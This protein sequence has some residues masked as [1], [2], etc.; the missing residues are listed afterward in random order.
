MQSSAPGTAP[1]H[2]R[3]DVLLQDRFRPFGG[4]LL[5]IHAARGRCHE[6]RL[7]LAAI[8]QNP[9]IKFLLDRQRF[10]DQQAM[11]NAAFRPRLVRHQ[12]HA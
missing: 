9:E 11:H 7:A 6:H 12:L 8:D 10:F 3:V 1:A 4:H 5:N 2:A